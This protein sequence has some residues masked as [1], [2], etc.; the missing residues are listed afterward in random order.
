[1]NKSLIVA[2]LIGALS[3]TQAVRISAAPEETKDALPKTPG[4][5]AIDE[6]K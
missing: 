1:M 6:S 4:V 2:L 5:S 3:Q